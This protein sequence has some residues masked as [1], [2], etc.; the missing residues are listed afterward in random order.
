MEQL[1]RR[2]Q[3]EGRAFGTFGEASNAVHEHLD[4]IATVRARTSWR[5]MGALS[6]GEAK[7]FLVTSLRR[8]WATAIRRA[9]SRL[10][11]ARLEMVG[12]RGRGAQGFVQGDHDVAAPGLFD[13]G[14]HADVGGVEVGEGR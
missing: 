13:A 11:F 2:Y 1:L 14:V 10:R 8:R 9:N 12:H 4:T 6:F 3:V 7:A 5:S